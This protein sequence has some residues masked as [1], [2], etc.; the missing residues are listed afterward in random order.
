MCKDLREK[1]K[2]QTAEFSFDLSERV[3]VEGQKYC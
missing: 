2:W 1:L 3:G